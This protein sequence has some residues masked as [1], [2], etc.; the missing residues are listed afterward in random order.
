MK[1]HTTIEEIT[2]DDLVDLLSTSMYGSNYLG[3]GYSYSSDLAEYDTHE[4]AMAAVLL[5]GGHIRVTDYQA[6]FSGNGA[7]TRISAGDYVKLYVNGTLMMSDTPMEKRTNTDFIDNAHGDV[8]IAGLGIGL[9][10][11]NL[12]EKVKTGEVTSITVYEKYQDVID[13]VSPYYKHLPLTVKCADILEYK[14]PKD[15]TYDTIYFDIWPTIDTD[16]LKEIKLLHNRWKFRKRKGGWMD[17]WVKK[18]LQN[19]N[20]KSYGSY[21]W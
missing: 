6:A 13:L 19:E 14:P 17:S 12:E 3:A 7:L 18:F 5:K 20:R 9:I 16:N 10:L 15:E 4:D 8:M 2:H 1:T 11:H 21:W